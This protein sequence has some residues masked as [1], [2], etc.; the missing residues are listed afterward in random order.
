M[1]K[2]L[3]LL[4]LT[5]L[6]SCAS[7]PYKLTDKSREVEVLKRA[8]KDDCEV[9]TKVIGTH[10]KG[11]TELARN[12]ARNKAASKGADSIFIEDEISN[13]SNREV[14]ATAYKCN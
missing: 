11:S 4:S 7:D 6:V 14:V 5:L 13:G 3:I 1:S 8:P 10:S 2:Y 9:V 12:M